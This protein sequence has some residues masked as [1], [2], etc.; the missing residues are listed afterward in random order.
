MFKEYE[1]KRLKEKYKKGTRVRLISME[2]S[3]AVP[4]GT[5]GT[6]DFVDD[7]GSIFVNWDNG[8]GLALIYGVDEFEIIYDKDFEKDIKM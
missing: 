2:D 7:I 6:V 1:I 5:K 8:S 3:Q 4:S